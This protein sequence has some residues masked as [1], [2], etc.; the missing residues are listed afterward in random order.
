[1]PSMEIN[2][3]MMQARPGTSACARMR[4]P[5]PAGEHAAP[6]AP[7]RDGREGQAED[8]AARQSSIMLYLHVYCSAC[9]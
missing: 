3:I 5:A 7:R 4:M 8:V 1:M 9:E 2:G 6:G